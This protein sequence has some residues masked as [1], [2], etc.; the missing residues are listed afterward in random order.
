MGCEKPDQQTGNKEH[1][2]WQSKQNSSGVGF[3]GCL[4]KKFHE[5]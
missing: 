1:R 5:L 4:K 2:D 3:F